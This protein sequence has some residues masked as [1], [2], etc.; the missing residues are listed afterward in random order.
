MTEAP[1]PA[2]PADGS[3]RPGDAKE[4]PRNRAP[5]QW[6]PPHPPELDPA[7][8]LFDR[9]DWRGAAAEIAALLASNP[10]DEVAAA[11][12]A[13]AARMAPD[14]WALRVGLA[15]L[16]LLALLCVLYVL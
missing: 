11:S 4:D 3:P 7:W 12:R 16:G 2:A 14:P 15:A 6:P 1:E 10:P 8:A 5:E 13:L 9:G